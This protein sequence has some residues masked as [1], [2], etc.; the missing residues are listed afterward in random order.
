VVADKRDRLRPLRIK[1]LEGR[2]LIGR[3]KRK[4]LLKEAFGGIGHD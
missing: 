1:G 2:R 4:L 3:E